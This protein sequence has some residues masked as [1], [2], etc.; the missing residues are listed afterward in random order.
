M[1]LDTQVNLSG[2]TIRLGH[3]VRQLLYWTVNYMKRWHL[4][5]FSTPADFTF[6]GSA[7]WGY[8]MLLA[9][10]VPVCSGQLNSGLG[11]IIL[12]TIRV[13]SACGWVPFGLGLLLLRIIL[14][15]LGIYF[16]LCQFQ[17]FGPLKNLY[18]RHYKMRSKMGCTQVSYWLS[19]KPVNRRC[20]I[21]CYWESIYQHIHLSE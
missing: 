19:L 15:L 14:C 2:P 5:L 12:T 13:K 9:V 10:L 17:N 7:N 16:V 21:C 3:V 20:I 8:I 6:R 11:L 4:F 18:F 1:G